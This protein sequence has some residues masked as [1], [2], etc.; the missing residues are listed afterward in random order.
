[1]TYCSYSFQ[2]LY[3]SIECQIS[4]ENEVRTQYEKK[5]EFGMKA[6]RVIKLFGDL[7]ICFIIGDKHEIQ[8]DMI[9]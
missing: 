5:C 4:D 1:M 8:L 7:M 6:A 2:V 3:V 9:R